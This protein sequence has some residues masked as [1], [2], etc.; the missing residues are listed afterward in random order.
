MSRFD[1]WLAIEV[2]EY[3]ERAAKAEQL[4]DYLDEVHRECGECPDLRIVE[5]GEEDHGKD[6][7]IVIDKDGQQVSEHEIY[8]EAY[9]Q[10]YGSEPPAFDPFLDGDDLP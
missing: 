6:C 9:K 1:S 5:C 3:F 10:V 2:D 4:N 8:S 7:Y